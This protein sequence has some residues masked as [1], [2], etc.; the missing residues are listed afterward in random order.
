[1]EMQARLAAGVARLVA[2][3]NAVD[4]KVASLT[5]G[6]SGG[7]PAL[8][9]VEIDLGLNAR[10][11]GQF[12]IAGTDMVVGKPVFIQQAAGPYTGKGTLPDEAEMDM[13][14]V[15][16]FVRS[17]TVIQCYWNAGSAVLSGNIKFN[18]FIGA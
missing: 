5:P 16:G 13:L 7:N 3:I 18:Y 15:T 10:P 2:A 12:E 8:A 6:G 17:A 14:T 11:T 9:T 1:M 4:V